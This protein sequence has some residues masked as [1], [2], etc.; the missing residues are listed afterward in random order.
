MMRA[1][2]NLSDGGSLLESE[3]DLSTIED[4]DVYSMMN[5]RGEPWFG[6]AFLPRAMLIAESG[7]LPA[8]LRA[9]TG[10]KD[11]GMMSHSVYQGGFDRGQGSCFMALMS[12]GKMMSLLDLPMEATEA[13]DA[14]GASRTSAL[15]DSLLHL[16]A[17]RTETGFTFELAVD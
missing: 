5:Y 4:V 8:A 13:P 9:A 7:I 11:A 10:V 16:T 17:R 6:L 14:S 15:F 2:E 1:F 12:M 3:F